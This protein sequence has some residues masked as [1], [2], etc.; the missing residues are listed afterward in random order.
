MGLLWLTVWEYGS[1]CWEI[2]GHKHEVA[3]HI[4]STIRK[5]RA[6]LAGPQLFPCLCGPGSRLDG[7][8]RWE[9]G[10]GEASHFTSWNHGDLPQACPEDHILG[11]LRCL[12]VDNYQYASYCLTGHSWVSEWFSLIRL[13]ESLH[14]HTWLS[15]WNVHQRPPWQQSLVVAISQT[16]VSFSPLGTLRFQFRSYSLTFPVHKPYVQTDQFL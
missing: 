9:D 2:L 4:V 11:V 5:Q 10:M 6:M 3:G 7:R 13:R 8:M 15:H 1:S 12:Q 16:P 14:N